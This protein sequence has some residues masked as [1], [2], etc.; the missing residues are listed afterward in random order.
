MKLIRIASLA[1]VMASVM[2]FITPT[3]ASGGDDVRWRGEAVWESTPTGAVTKVVGDTACPSGYSLAA[4]D[5]V[6]A[7]RA[8]ACST[9]DTWD[10]ARLSDG[11]SISGSGYGC[12]VRRRDTR[13]LGHAVCKR[14]MKF[15]RGTGDGVCPSGYTVASSTAVR[16]N[17]SLICNHLGTWDVGRLS[18]GGSMDGSGYGCRIRERDA[19]SLDHT[20]CVELDFVK[21]IGDRPCPAG[22]ALISPQKAR[23]RRAELCNELDP[24]DIVRLDGG[25]SMSGPGYDC[26]IRNADTRILG[27]ALCGAL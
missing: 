21:A 5:E 17:A 1:S 18:G 27:Q 7:N 10:I 2:A 25:G 4:P 16:A 13:D 19:R 12:K 6:L 20:I 26:K 14:A 22:T 24:W 15:T 11:A 3:H 9:L 8:E 23:A